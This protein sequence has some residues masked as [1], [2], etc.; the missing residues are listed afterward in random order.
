MS[1]IEPFTP[2]G[3]D[4]NSSYLATCIN[5]VNTNYK[6]AIAS[7]VPDPTLRTDLNAN[8]LQT[9][10]NTLSINK[11]DLYVGIN[12]INIINIK[13]SPYSAIGDGIIDDT[14]AISSAISALPASNAILY[15]PRGKYKISNTLSINNK[16][17]LIIVSDNAEIIVSQTST[18]AMA[19]NNCK[20]L[21]AF[22]GHITFTTTSVASSPTKIALLL[23]SPVQTNANPDLAN[24]TI[25][26]AFQ[27]GLYMDNN[28]IG[29]TNGSISNFTFD[30]ENT[31]VNG[32]ILTENCQ[33]IEITNC[34]IS[35]L[36]GTGI[37][38][39]GGNN[40][41]TGGNITN[42]RIGIWVDAI[43]GGNLDHGLINGTTCNHCRACGIFMRSL[44]LNHML[45]NCK[46][47]ATNGPDTL[48]EASNP[49]SRGFRYGVYLENVKGLVMTGNTVA[50]NNTID[51]G[52]DG[53]NTSI[54]NNNVFRSVVS[55]AYTIY[56]WGF[57]SGSSNFEVQI[58][59]NVFSGTTANALNVWGRFYL[60]NT[61]NDGARNY[62]IKNN[63]VENVSTTLSMTINSGDYFIGCHNEY[64]IKNDTIFTTNGTDPAGQTANIYLLPHITGTSFIISFMSGVQ[65]ALQ[66]VWLRYKTNNTGL[67]PYIPLPASG[68]VNIIYITSS[69]CFRIANNLKRIEFMPIN[70]NT[71]GN[72]CV[73]GDAL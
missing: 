5:R 9:N 49:T 45:V 35:N 41:I 7:I 55:C 71:L 51:L 2:E 25:L 63:T 13:S 34:K 60:G 42:A 22:I 38:M 29:Y 64:I 67:A 19:F 27:Y 21:H 24:I 39:K 1:S 47:W 56:E 33:Y 31:G 6:T 36:L 10:T 57:G 18:T 66:Y 43:S 48:T 68:A 73:I 8:I 30:G 20:N 28:Q 61:A 54:I 72:W 15:F 16:T 70:N 23:T 58:C 44:Q 52:I 59:N 32:I 11:L 65:N 14:S 26:G 37:L 50:H 40:I 69:R 46:I 17:K 4:P 53:L 62:I 12:D 3:I